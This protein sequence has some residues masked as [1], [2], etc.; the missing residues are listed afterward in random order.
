MIGVDHRIKGY[1]YG[2]RKDINR[3]IGTFIFEDGRHPS[4]EVEASDDAEARDKLIALAE[5]E[6]N[7][8]G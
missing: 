1:R 4:F 7:K 5:R 3:W 2:L 8:D 6:L